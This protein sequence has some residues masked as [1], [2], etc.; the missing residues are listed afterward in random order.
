VLLQKNICSE[1]T[2]QLADKPASYKTHGNDTFQHR[3]SQFL[4]TVIF[5]V[6]YVYMIVC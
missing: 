3:V 2:G 1:I 4:H 6:Q 5:P